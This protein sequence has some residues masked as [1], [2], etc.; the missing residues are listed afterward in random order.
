MSSIKA[1][2]IVL[3]WETSSTP[4][5]KEPLIKKGEETFLG[6]AYN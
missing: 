5:S 6:G 3:R 1:H 4:L 2:G